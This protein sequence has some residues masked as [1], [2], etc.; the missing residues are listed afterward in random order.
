[1]AE[2]D[3]HSHYTAPKKDQHQ[4]PEKFGNK[5]GGKILFHV[6]VDFIINGK[7]KSRFGG[8]WRNPDF[9]KLWAGQTISEIGSRITRDGVPYAAVIVLNAPPSQMGFLTAVGAASVLLFG[10]LAGVW[11]DRFRRRPIMI[12]ADLA[13]AAILASIPIAALTHRLSMAQLYVVIAL[14]GFCTVFF[15]VAYQSYLPSLV[16]R[17]NLLEGNS[18]LAMSASVAEIAGPSLTGILVQLITAPIAILFDAISFLVSAAGVILIRK[19]EQ[20]Y[21]APTSAPHPIAGLRFVFSHP[22]L[23]PL[24]CFSITAFLSLGIIG[25]LYVLYAIRELHI[26]PAELG[27]AIAMGGAGSLIGASLAPAIGR[28]FGLGHTFIGS[29]LTMAAAYA[30]IPLAHG[31]RPLPLIFLMLSQ[32][33]G[34]FALSTYMINVLTLRQSVA[35]EEML[36]RVNA[37]M[38]LMTRGAFPLSALAGGI[39]ASAIGIRQTLAIAVAGVAAASLWLIASPLRKLGASDAL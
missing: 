17:E 37:A 28:R 3:H 21:Q 30:L 34:D 7:S 4:C 18:K 15:D 29:V 36:G 12:A 39:L 6:K 33:V 8:L 9:M 16:E 38:Q 13:R 26:T 2:K 1:V 20:R 31:P 11:V 27:I 23:R 5:F 25:P 19:P 24:A 32:L 22:L 14:A 10:L 35:P